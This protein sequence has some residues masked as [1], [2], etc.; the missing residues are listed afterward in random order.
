[1]VIM[2]AVVHSRFATRVGVTGQDRARR[3]ERARSTLVIDSVDGASDSSGFCFSVCS[4]TT[5]D[6]RLLGACSSMNMP[7]QVVVFAAACSRC[8]SHLAI[9]Q[10]RSVLC[11]MSADDKFTECRSVMVPIESA[12]HLREVRVQ[13]AEW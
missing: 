1:M 2:H 10:K 11:A 7:R 13:L 3:L 12:L 6:V 4:A 5:K 8:S 9:Q